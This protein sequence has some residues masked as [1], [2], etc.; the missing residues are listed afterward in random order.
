MRAT[1]TLA[2]VQVKSESGGGWYN[3]VQANYNYWVAQS[4]VGAGPFT[5]RLADIQ[6]H[7]VTLPGIALSPG[8]VQGAGTWMYGAGTTTEPVS[9]PTPAPHTSRPVASATSDRA[10]ASR[11]ATASPAASEPSA[12]LGPSRRQ[13]SPPGAIPTC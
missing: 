11:A 6:G 7:V 5:V 2:S 10:P 8:V 9:T 3:L 13:A 4:G 12:G 1:L